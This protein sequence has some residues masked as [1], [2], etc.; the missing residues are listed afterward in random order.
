M[1]RLDTFRLLGKH[2][3]GILAGVYIAAAAARL[4]SVWWPAARVPAFVIVSLFFALGGLSVMIRELTKGRLSTGIILF[5][6]LPILLIGIG[7]VLLLGEF[8]GRYWSDGRG[9]IDFIG[10]YVWV[11]NVIGGAKLVVQD[12]NLKEDLEKSPNELLRKE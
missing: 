7:F 6:F 10:I 9:I 5:D 4:L 11:A 3:V 1:I 2:V 12:R 8:V